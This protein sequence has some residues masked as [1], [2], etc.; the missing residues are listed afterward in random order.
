M[1]ACTKAAGSNIQAAAK[2]ASA[3]GTAVVCGAND[4]LLIKPDSLNETREKIV[5]DSLGQYHPK[6]S[7]LTTRN[8]GGSIP[9]WLRYDGVEH[10]LL[11]LLMGTSG[12]APVQQGVTA[13]YK[14]VL[15][16]ADCLD[17]LF[18]TFCK[19]LRVNV[20]EYPSIKVQGLSLEGSIGQPMLLSFDVVASHREINSAVNDDTTFASVTIRE[21]AHRVLFSHGVFRMNAASGAALSGSDA[22]KPSSFRLNY[23]RNMKGIVGLGSDSN[24]ID[25]PTNNGRPE[26]T[27]SLK[28]DRHTSV[29]RFLAFIA[30]TKQKMD[31]VFTGSLIESPYYRTFKLE[32]PS[33]K[34]NAVH[35]PTAEGIIPQEVE[36][37]C[38]A[39]TAAPSGMTATAP[40]GVEIINTRTTDLLA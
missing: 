38:L 1:P 13:A 31:I 34:Y 10:L 6:D 27:L 36:M 16:I 3:W 17:G 15:S 5:D 40:F 23:K 22:I 8:A 37:E 9:A 14:Q 29:D 2:K 7:D 24:S 11:A 33:L 25:E 35:T 18:A 26:C 20:D 39:V 12:G 19:N 28:F 32:L 4:G 21:S 30:E